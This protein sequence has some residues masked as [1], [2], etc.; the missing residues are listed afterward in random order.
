MIKNNLLIG[1]ILASLPLASSAEVFKCKIG[2]K[3]VFQAHKCSAGDVEQIEIKRRNP[4]VDAMEAEKLQQWKA[5]YSVKSSVEREAAAVARQ[6]EIDRMNA[7]DASQEPNKVIT[8]TKSP[9][10]EAIEKVDKRLKTMHSQ[11]IFD[12]NEQNTYNIL[13]R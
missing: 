3:T 1:I 12:R 2:E 8:V 10:L 11:Q 4:E 7:F 13:H 5:D 6:N 9:E